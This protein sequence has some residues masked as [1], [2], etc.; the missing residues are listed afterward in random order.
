M[1][2]SFLA[3]SIVGLSCL[4]VGAAMGQTRSMPSLTLT[5]PNPNTQYERPTESPHRARKVNTSRG[6]HASH[7][8]H[9]RAGQEALRS[10]GFDPGG[11]DGR[12]GPKTQAAIANYQRDHGLRE[13]GRF[14]QRTLSALGVTAEG[15]NTSRSASRLS[16]N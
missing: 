2:R 6:R 9:V 11:V 4:S 15:A 3:V 10:Q 7:E 8:R 1:K 14:D 16:T 5:D 12:Y 13:T